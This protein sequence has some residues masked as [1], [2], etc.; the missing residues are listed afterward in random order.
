MP[1]TM[2]LARNPDVCPDWESNQWPF[3]SQA[4]AQSSEL[5]QPG[6]CC[7]LRTTKNDNT[8]DFYTPASPVQQTV[9][10]AECA[11]GLCCCLSEPVLIGQPSRTRT[12]CPC[13]Q[14]VHVGGG[15]VTLLLETFLLQHPLLSRIKKERRNFWFPADSPPSDLV[16]EKGT[17]KT[18]TQVSRGSRKLSVILLI[19][20]TKKKCVG[21]FKKM[22]SSFLPSSLASLPPSLPSCL[23]GRLYLNYFGSDWEK[24]NQGFHERGTEI[25]GM[26]PPCPM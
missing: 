13:P 7:I 20:T 19:F 16:W 11:P 14:E 9:I 2:D 3:G 25:L 24:S 22:S 5:H 4:S 21:I 26:R 1:P 6:L 12:A 8:R 10:C 15:G 17:R 23:S 18:W